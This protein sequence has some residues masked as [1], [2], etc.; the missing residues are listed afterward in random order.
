MK[1][2]RIRIRNVTS[3][4]P[5]HWFGLYLGYTGTN[6]VHAAKLLLLLLAMMLEYPTNGTAVADVELNIIAV[7][8]I[9]HNTR[10]TVLL[11]YHSDHS[12]VYSFTG[13]LSCS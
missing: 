1:R 11:V 7:S 12:T 3:S 2:C 5:K 8:P 9:L 4:D 6:V 10:T 13:L